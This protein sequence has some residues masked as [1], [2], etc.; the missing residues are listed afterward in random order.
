MKR[1]FLKK[2][3]SFYLSLCIL[4]LPIS[5]NAQEISSDISTSE[6]EKVVS[7]QNG[8]SM[9][10]D[11]SE[12]IIKIK[13]YSVNSMQRT[14][15][16][17]AFSITMLPNVISTFSLQESQ[18]NTD[19]NYAYLVETENVK[20]GELTQAGEMR[21]YGCILDQTS[22][23]SI[24]LQSVSDVDTDIYV[25][26]LDENTNGLNLIG[27]SAT[28]GFGVS[29]YYSEILNPG[30]YY[31]AISA[32]EGNGQ[33]AFAFYAT[34]DL[35]NEVNDDFD[36]ATVIEDSGVIEGVIDNPFDQDIYSFTLQS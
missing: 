34:Q 32:Y 12:D 5:V 30:I 3:L 13:E 14:Y 6:Q 19:P 1:G 11:I 35:V 31:F 28:E 24:M 21:W 4:L 7:D 16:A 23:V 2:L 20:Q 22:K 8:I 17:E 25:F 15:D 27:G 33:Y 26:Q 18:E 36:I 29:E 9:Y 10:E